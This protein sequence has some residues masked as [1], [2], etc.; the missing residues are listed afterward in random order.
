LFVTDR[1]SVRQIYSWRRDFAGQ[2]NWFGL[3]NRTLLAIIVWMA[4]FAVYWG[5]VL[6]FQRTGTPNDAYFHLL[7]DAF[8]HGRLNLVEPPDTEDLTLFQGQWYLAYPPLPA[9]LG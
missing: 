7:A 4:A 6:F 8:L 2:E 1:S 3:Q 9:C 5:T